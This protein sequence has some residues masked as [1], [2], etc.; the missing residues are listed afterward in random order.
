MCS[1]SMAMS[2]RSLPDNRSSSAVNTRAPCPA[3]SCAPAATAR[4]SRS[5]HVACARRRRF[6]SRTQVACCAIAS[7][8]TGSCAPGL[9]IKILQHPATGTSRINGVR[10]VAVTCLSEE[11]F[12]FFDVP[13]RR[14]G[15]PE[16]VQMAGRDGRRNL[17][18]RSRLTKALPHTFPSVVLSHTLSRPFVPPTPR[19]A[20]DSYWRAHPIRADRLARSLA[21]KPLIY[22]D[23]CRD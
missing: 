3:V 19:L 23:R 12:T 4:T 8:P 10:Q 22:R 7:T 1:A 2:R 14:S 21:K 6:G 16:R 13:C 11:G 18:S 17:Q 20:I 15:A 5:T 9:P